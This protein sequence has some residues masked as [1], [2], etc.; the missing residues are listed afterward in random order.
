VNKMAKTTISVLVDGGKASAGAPLGPALGPLGLNIG[1][2]IAKINEKTKEFEGIKVPVKIIADKA[3]KSLEVEVSSPPVS[4]LLKK[5][6]GLEKGS[7]EPGKTNVKDVSLKEIIEVARMKKES[8]L[9]KDL[10]AATKI[11]L[12]SCVSM[13]IIVEGKSP[14][15]I[16]ILIDEGQYDS[17]FGE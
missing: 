10:K 6:F 11:V 8:L 3:T 16:Q 14:K 2:V 9:S 15:E 4:A 7:T 13:G 1:E 12:G 17:E 5:K